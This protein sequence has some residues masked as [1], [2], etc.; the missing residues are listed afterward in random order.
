MRTSSYPLILTVL[1]VA[2]AAS[3]LPSI[4]Y[5]IK[6]PLDC[7][8]VPID[9]GMYGSPCFQD[10]D[11]DGVSDL[12]IGQYDDGKIRIYLNEGT[13]ENLVFNSWE[14]MQADGVDITLPYG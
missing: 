9:I 4:F 11:G 10:W 13:N 7:A 12:I 6:Q 1:I 8:G 14:F 3:A 5:M 2:G